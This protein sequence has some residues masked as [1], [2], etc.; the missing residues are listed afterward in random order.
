MSTADPIRLQFQA[1]LELQQ[2]TLPLV[3]DPIVHAAQLIF[4]RIIQGNKI[5]ACGNGSGAGFAQ[6]FVAKMLHRFEQERPGLPALN[7]AADPSTLTAIASE[8]SIDEIFAKQVA[9]LG[10]SCDVLILSTCKGEAIN[11]MRAIQEAQERDMTSIALTGAGGELA[12]YLGAED[13]LI[14]V[15]SDSEPRI[16]ELH[17]LILNCLCDLIDRQL[18][19][20]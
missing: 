17:V 13:I 12:S 7:L 16:E 10:Q 6:N 5:L 3:A 8:D 2:Q 9:A 11:L 1:H 19:G 15:P 14:R 20:H 18:L 4:G